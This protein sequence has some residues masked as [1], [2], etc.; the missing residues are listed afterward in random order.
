[1]RDSMMLH[2]AMMMAVEAHKGQVRKGTDI[3]YIVHPMEVLQILTAMNGDTELLIAG[4]LHDIVED[5]AVTAED[6]R[7]RFGDVVADLVCH[8]TEDK[9]KSWEERKQVTIDEIYKG[10][11]SVRYLIFA[12]MLSNLRSQWA[13]YQ[14]VGESLWERFNA[15]K[16]KQSWYY[17]ARLDAFDDLMDDECAAKFYWEA[18]ALYKDIYVDFYMDSENSMLYQKSAHGEGYCLMFNTV[19]WQ[20]YDGEIP[21][22]CVRIVRALAERLEENDSAAFWMRHTCDCTDARYLLGVDS[23]YI[24]TFALE[25]GNIFFFIEKEDQDEAVYTYWFD[26]INARRLLVQLRIEYEVEMSLSDALKK[27]FGGVNIISRLLAFCNKNQVEY[28][29]FVYSPNDR[30]ECSLIQ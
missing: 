12:D 9:S 29:N 7:E 11:R 13:D 23:G 16:E 15:P 3:P 5:T 14:K 30:H 8:H 10:E 1:M 28:K 22:S 17:S 25:N 6:I 19:Q 26:E 18:Q 27:A 4:V 20:R 21:K 2:E 24:H